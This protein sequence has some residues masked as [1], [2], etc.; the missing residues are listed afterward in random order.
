MPKAQGK[1]ITNKSNIRY[2]SNFTGSSGFMLLTKKKSYLF[3]DF[4]YIERAKNCIKKGIEIIDTTKLWKNKKELKENWQK[5]LKKHKVK[6]LGIE[7]SNLTVTQFKK[8][9]KISG[10]IKYIDISG[11]IEEKRAIKSK[12][13]YKKP[14]NKW[15]SLPRDQKNC[16]KSYWTKKT[17]TTL[18]NWLS[19]EN[20]GT[21][22]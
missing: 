19:M 14:K 17:N 11:E 13:T 21:W 15:K 12:I 3:T 20:K 2:L 5:I 9:K 16:T 10:K 1:L 8:Y 18:R 6:T 22:Q 4:R 7:E